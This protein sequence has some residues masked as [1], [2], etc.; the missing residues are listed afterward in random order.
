MLKYCVKI[1]DL[2]LSSYICRLKNIFFE[3]FLHIW[4]MKNYYCH[5]AKCFRSPCCWLSLCAFGSHV[6]PLYF[7]CRKQQSHI[8]V[9]KDKKHLKKSLSHVAVWCVISQIS[10]KGL[11][12]QACQF[13]QLHWCMTTNNIQCK[14]LSYR[15]DLPQ[16][17]NSFWKYSLKTLHE[18][19]EFGLINMQCHQRFPSRVSKMNTTL[20]S[21]FIKCDVTYSI[22]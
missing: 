22:F 5:L 2:Y 9:K 21:R 18:L 17:G 1:H 7:M 10:Y 14:G 6:I 12:M 8:N 20:L 15:I 3:W 4:T 11:D 13:F 16:S 19:K